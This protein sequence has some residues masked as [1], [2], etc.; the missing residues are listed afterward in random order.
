MIDRRKF[1]AAAGAAA[2]AARGSTVRTTPLKADFWGTQYY[3]SKEQEQLL[4][5]LESRKPFRW[6]GT[7]SEPP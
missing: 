7:G 5:V 6:Y 1:L 3:D 2:G 4:D